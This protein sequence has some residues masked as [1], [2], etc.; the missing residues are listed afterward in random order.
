MSDGAG[1]L[2]LRNSPAG[3]LLLPSSVLEGTAA[4]VVFEPPLPPFP[5]SEPLLG[6]L[7][8]GLEGLGSLG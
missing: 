1:A 2:P 6:S 4:E 7:E 3:M 5:L 8:T